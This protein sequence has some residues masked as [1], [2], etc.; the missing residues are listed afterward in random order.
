MGWSV[1]VWGDFSCLTFRKS[2][3]GYLELGSSCHHVWILTHVKRYV[4]IC[5]LIVQMMH[6]YCSCFGVGFVQCGEISAWTFWKIWLHFSNFQPGNKTFLENKNIYIAYG[7][8]V[9]SWWIRCTH[10]HRQLPIYNQSCI[11]LYLTIFLQHQKTELCKTYIFKWTN[12]AYFQPIK[13]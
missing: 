3:S 9:Q 4:N 5:I 7:S 1:D 11:L 8:N 2:L 10:F 13:L 12:T 6:S